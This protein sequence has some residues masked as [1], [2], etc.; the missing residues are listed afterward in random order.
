MSEKQSWFEDLRKLMPHVRKEIRTLDLSTKG[1]EGVNFDTVSA[2]W[3]LRQGYPQIYSILTGGMP[4]WS[5]EAVSV[6]TALNHSVVWACNR[7]IS[8][9]I[10]FIPAVLRQKTSAGKREAVEHPM[11]NAMQ[12]APND[13]ITAQCF[14]EEL[15]S[16]CVMS[17]N[18]Y[19]KIVRRSGTGTAIE[20]HGLLPQQVFPDREKSG[21]KRLV[22]VIKEDYAADKTYTVERGKPQDILHLRGLGWDG[23]RGYSVITMGRQSIG[24]AIAA[25][26]N[27]A[28]FWASGGR[29]PY[30]IEAT[31]KFKVDEDFQKWRSDWERVYAEPSRVPIMEPDFVYKPDAASMK[32][33]QVIESRIFTVAEIC[34][35]FNVSPHLAM[36]LSRATFSNIEELM[37][38]FVILT[39]NAWINRWENE[40]WRCVLTA[41]E[42]AK[43]Y[44]L[45][46]DLRSL[47]RGDFATRM[48][49][50]ATAI[51]NGYL[52]QDEVR[53][54]EDL[55]PIPDGKGKTYRVQLNMQ[56]ISAEPQAQSVANSQPKPVA[57]SPARAVVDNRKKENLRRIV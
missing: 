32:D 14:T 28:R 15:T 38:E 36:D 8:E 51:Q 3:Y 26:R 12:N 41:E 33:S 39:L 34:R 19:A 17:G 49:G 22:Y 21:Q 29:A 16:H 4:A 9:T 13:E 48:A 10:G 56:D 25:E 6:E 55:D 52:N 30:H 46:H 20:L 31:R 35:W 18:G 40:F 27:V 1:G 23:L 42:K 7:I 2:G 11:Y 47:L 45:K 54:D 50:Y 43:G 5:G 37:L 53:D 57:D 44:Y 24:T